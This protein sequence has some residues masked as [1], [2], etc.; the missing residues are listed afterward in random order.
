MVRTR[1]DLLQTASRRSN[2]RGRAVVLGLI[3]HEEDVRFIASCRPSVTVIE[4]ETNRRPSKLGGD[5]PAFAIPSVAKNV[6]VD[7]ATQE[8]PEDVAVAFLL[9]NHVTM[10]STRFRR[11][12]IIVGDEETL[13]VHLKGHH[14]IGLA[15]Y[16]E[17]I[18]VE[19]A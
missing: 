1:T 17:L 3:N 5:L 19:I 15:Q 11:G 7:L 4:R 16:R 8:W 18:A 6:K 13:R 14:F 12:C 9:D 10:P 2:K